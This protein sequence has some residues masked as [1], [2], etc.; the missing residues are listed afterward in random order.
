MI[1]KIKVIRHIKIYRILINK[2]NITNVRQIS[3]VVHDLS[4]QFLMILIKLK[5]SVVL[6]KVYEY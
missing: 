3:I 1:L 5:I 2:L 4:K 6:P